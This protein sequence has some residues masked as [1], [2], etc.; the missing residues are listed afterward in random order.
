M[1]LILSGS[2]CCGK[3]TIIKELL[4]TKDNLRYI[5]TFTSREKRVIICFN[6]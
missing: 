4:K 3:N 1:I 5:T 2:S 6:V